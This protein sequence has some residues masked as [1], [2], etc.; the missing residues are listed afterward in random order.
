MPTSEHDHSPNHYHMTEVNL[1]KKEEG[2]DKSPRV[3]QLKG[4]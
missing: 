4:R 1:E 2:D 3:E